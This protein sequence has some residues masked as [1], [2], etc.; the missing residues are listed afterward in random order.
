MY[1]IFVAVI[2]ASGGM[3]FGYDLASRNRDC[4]ILAPLACSAEL[5][6]TNSRPAPVIWSRG[7][8][9]T[10]LCSPLLYRA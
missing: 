8:C 4:A 10:M 9:L 7:I 1:V 2:A 5:V 3:L 6:Y